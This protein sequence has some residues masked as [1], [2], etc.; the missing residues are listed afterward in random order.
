M[1]VR[2]LILA[3][4]SGKRFWPRSTEEKPKQ[5]LKI[6]S[7]RTMIQE[8]FDRISKFVRKEDIFVISNENHSKHVSDQLNLPK[9][10]ILLEP[11]AKNTA[12]AIAW[13]ISHF[14]ENDVVVVL[15]SDHY[16]EDVDAYLDTL[17]KAVKFSLENDAILTLGIK[18]TK[19]ETGYGYIEVEK[20]AIHNSSKDVIAG[21]T[22]SLNLF[23]KVKRFHEKPNLETAY[24]YVESGNF[25][26]N[27]G[28]F[29]FKVSVMKKAFKKY[30]PNTYK[31][32]FEE[33]KDVEKAY[34]LADSISID[35]GILEKAENIYV[36]ISEFGW[37]DVG[38]WDALYEMGEKDENGNHAE[39][40]V[41]FRNAKNCGV[42]SNG[43][44][45]AVSHVDDIIVVV[46]E[47]GVLV[48]RR[49]TTQDV[50][51]LQLK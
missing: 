15:P 40:K 48:T 34:E 28:M 26:W 29:I 39:G 13:G 27:S 6:T 1:S 16:I 4:G 17:K 22:R 45:V 19:A 25:F 30:L 44:P 23:Y 3:G 24:S 32:F 50:K 33:K 20:S 51:N 35:Y 18:P 43:M 11:V 8:T 37:N 12:P 7:D 47:N 42:F 49:G 2:A 5:F 38:S 31:A 14:C 9:G 46:D 41:V 36:V 21:L 10:N